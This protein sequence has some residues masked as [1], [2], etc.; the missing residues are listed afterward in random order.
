MRTTMANV[1]NEIPAD[2][3]RTEEQTETADDLRDL[4][5]EKDVKRGGPRQM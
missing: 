3:V 2:D 4:E 1:E 5:L